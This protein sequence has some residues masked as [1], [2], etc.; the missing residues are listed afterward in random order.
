[1]RPRF[2]KRKD[3]IMP[4]YIMQLIAVANRPGMISF[5][6]GL[7]D[8]RL[9]DTEG[10]R[11]AADEVLSGEHACDALQYGVTEGL[12]SLRKKI[13]DRCASQLGFTTSPD[14]VFVT[15]GSQECFDHLG[16]MFLDRGDSMIVEN[17]GYLGALQSYSTYAPK[18]IGVDLDDEGPDL[19]A[20]EKALSVLPKL[21]YGIPNHQNPSGTSYSSDARERIAELLDGSETLMIEDD[22]YGELGYRGRAGK[23]VRSMSHNVVLTGSFSKTISPAMRIGWMIVPDWL[24]EQTKVSVEAGSLHAGLFAQTVV[25]RFL[26]DN[27]FDAY[28]AP[29]RKEYERKKNLFIDLMADDLPSSMRWNDPTGGM[30]VWL[31]TPDGTDAMK[32]YDAAL[33]RKLVIMPG[34]P[35]HVRGGENTIRLN[36]ATAGDEDIKK[37]MKLL[38]AACKDAFR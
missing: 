27:D 37:G 15:N 3:D 24:V 16:K 38:A 21:F 31:R 14:N 7:P 6:T 18:F 4:S 23:A 29:I 12:Y 19:T 8:K 35:F 2:S 22:A 20:F 26:D 32:L 36:F 33:K 13:A 1:M 30:F 5:A 34:R 9:F 17:P 11:R 25:D 10:I 28:L